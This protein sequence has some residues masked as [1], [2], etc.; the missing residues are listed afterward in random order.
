MRGLAAIIAT[1]AALIW[2]SLPAA[3]STYRVNLAGWIVAAY[4]GNISFSMGGMLGLKALVA[5]VVGLL[6]SLAGFRRA[7]SVDPALA[8]GGP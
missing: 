5:A 7:V 1:V 2:S 4:Y 6:A 3:A 8:F